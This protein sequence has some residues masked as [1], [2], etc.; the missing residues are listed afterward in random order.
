MSDGDLLFRYPA[1]THGN[2]VFGADDGGEIPTSQIVGAAAL[3]RPT[4]GG[5]VERIEALVASAVLVRPA[6]WAGAVV[7]V[8]DTQRPLVGHVASGF[9]DGRELEAG[10]STASQDARRMVAGGS[11]H[12][13]RA[14]AIDSAVTER[15]R[16]ARRAGFPIYVRMQ[17]G[18]ARGAQHSGAFADARRHRAG[19]AVSLQDGR[20]VRVGGSLRLRDGLHVSAAGSHMLFQ[21][22]RPIQVGIQG[23]VR[24]GRPVVLGGERTRFQDAVP[25]RPGIYTPAHPEP[26]DPCY[27]PDGDLVFSAPW[28]AHGNLI[29]VCERHDGPEPGETVVVPVRRIYTVINTATLR[30]VDGDVLIPTMAMTLTIDVDSWTWGFTART[31]GAALPDLEPSSSGEPVE[32]EARING[33]AYRALIEGITRERVFG[34]SDLNVTGRG[35]AAV[36][37]APYTPISTFGNPS[38][39][40]TAQQLANHVLTLNGV[41]L[42]W[43]VNWAPEDWLVPAGVFSHQ[44]SYM[45]ALNAIAG[46]AGAYIQPHRTGKSLDFLLRYPAKPWEWGDV[47]PDYELPSDVV[48]KEGV[49]WSDKPAYNRV[50]VRGVQAGV[51]GQVTRAGT[52]GDLEAPM[53]TDPLITTAVAARQRGLPVLADVGRQAAVSLRLPVLAETGII[54]PGKFVRYVDGGVTRIGLVRSTSAA[55]ERTEDKLTIWQTIGVETHVGL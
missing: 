23:R 52:A 6:A 12:Q 32:V 30:R 16:D 51:L 14:K 37:D 50:F 33:V 54:P 47:T 22:G 8:S 3:T 34:R 15:A 5:V 48:Q 17:D 46:A 10:A 19:G 40:R 2:L 53:V 42:G 38:N 44:G 43:T 49:V 31:P 35:K 24:R 45:T 27:V 28:V 55:I 41:S 9:Q 25:P 29:F 39:A 7:Y 26:E 21:D 13:Q 1:R 18:D 11:M 4:W 20:P 36:L